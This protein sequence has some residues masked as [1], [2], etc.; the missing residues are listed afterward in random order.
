MYSGCQPWPPLFNTWEREVPQASLSPPARRCSPL[1]GP[2]PVPRKPTRPRQRGAKPRRDLPGLHAA[3]PSGPRGQ[4]KHRPRGPGD[5]GRHASRAGDLDTC[6]GAG[7]RA[8]G[9]RSDAGTHRTEAGLPA[10]TQAAAGHEQGRKAA[11]AA[12]P[13]PQQQTAVSHGGPGPLPGARRHGAKAGGRQPAASAASRFSG[14]SAPPA[15]ETR[16][17]TRTHAPRVLTRPRPGVRTSTCPL[18]GRPRPRVGRW[19][20]RVTGLEAGAEEEWGG[21]KG[22]AY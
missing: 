9:S 6:A 21:L 22:V 20:G 18:G 2:F 1:V 19:E 7:S 15:Q 11:T 10:G 12:A 3:R 4:E 13:A 8:G 17:G 16:D 5:L 14:N